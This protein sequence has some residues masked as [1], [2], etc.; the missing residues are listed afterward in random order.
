MGF[1]RDAM[2]RDHHHHQSEEE[3]DEFEVVKDTKK[4]ERPQ[5]MTHHAHHGFNKGPQQN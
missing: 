3:D 5:N 2:K 4:K 1:N